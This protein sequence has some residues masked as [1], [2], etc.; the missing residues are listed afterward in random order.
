[1]ASVMVQ[2]WVGEV[3]NAVLQEALTNCVTADKQRAYT[4]QEISQAVSANLSLQWLDDDRIEQ[5]INIKV[6]GLYHGDLTNLKPAE[7]V[8]FLVVSAL[9]GDY[10]P[11][12]GSL[13]GSLNNKGISV[14]TLAQNK[15][16]DYEPELPCWIS[17]P[18]TSTQPG[19][20]FD[21]ILLYE[22]AD[23]VQQSAQH[24][25]DIFTALTRFVGNTTTQTT[26]AM[27]LVSTGSGG[28]DPSAILTAIFNGAKRTMVTDFLLAGLKIAV[29]EASQIG[30]MTTIF[31]QLKNQ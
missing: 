24:V 14:A 11:T 19:I 29:F 21:R 7:K 12:H 30:S 13:I 2:V 26:V 25:Q 28:A 17:Q 5:D 8:D 18:I 23:P 15:A 9:P 22:P 31:E 27:P 6:M 16:A 1:M 3:S 20:A 4:D 10:S